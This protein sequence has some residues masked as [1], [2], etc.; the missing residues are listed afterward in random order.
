[1][2]R[3]ALLLLFAAAACDQRACLAQSDLFSGFRDELIEECCL[4]LAFRGTRFPGASCEQAFIAADGGVY[5]PGDAGIPPDAGFSGDDNDDFRDPD[6]VPCLCDNVTSSQC[7][8][9][10]Q[11][12]A[13]VT[14][15]GA[16]VSQGTTLLRRA[17]CENA[18]RNV[19]VFDPLTS[20]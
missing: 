7:E 3:V 16:C 13:R 14:V 12:G 15:V 20:E 8:A 18:C 17:P 5:V 6:E 1:M 4:C 2:A 10:L 11:S 9:A 19:L